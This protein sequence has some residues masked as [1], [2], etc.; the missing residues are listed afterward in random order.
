[1]LS[2]HLN[3]QVCQ[4]KRSSCLHSEAV[5]SKKESD[6]IKIIRKLTSYENMCIDWLKIK[7]QGLAGNTELAQAVDVMMARAKRIHI[8]IISK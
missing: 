4:D 8:L 5:E 1:M 6:V 3:G 2:F 7:F